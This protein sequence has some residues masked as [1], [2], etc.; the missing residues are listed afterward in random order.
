MKKLFSIFAAILFAASISGRTTFNYS[1]KV[2]NQK[3]GGIT[4]KLST[5]ESLTQE[6]D[7]CT[8]KDEPAKT[9]ITKTMKYADWTDYTA[10][11]EAYVLLCL[12]DAENADLDKETVWA[13]LGFRTTA[14]DTK[15]GVPAGTYSI[16]NTELANTFMA[17]PGSTDTDDNPSLLYFRANY[18][19]EYYEPFYL[20]SGTVS[21]APV[22]NGV[23]IEVNATSYNGSS[24]KLSY[25]GPIKEYKEYT[26]SVKSADLTMGT[27]LGEGVYEQNSNI[28]IAATANPGY[29]FVQWSD[30]NTD[31]PREIKI[32]Q[33]TTF[34]AEFAVTTSGYCGSN[35]YWNFNALTSTLTISGSGDMYTYAAF[36]DVPWYLLTAQI[37]KVIIPEGLTSIDVTAFSG[38]T[39]LKV[40]VWNAISYTA[41]ASETV[42]PFYSIRTRI[43]D[44]EFGEKVKK[45]PAYLCYEM[46]A[47]TEIVLGSSVTNIGKH[48]FDGCEDLAAITSEATTPPNCGTDAFAGVSIFIPVYVPISSIEKYAKAPIWKDFDAFSSIQAETKTVEVV[49]ATP[50]ENSVVMKWPAADE[51][52]VYTLVIKRDGVTFCTLSFNAQGQL[53][54]IQFVPG[55]NGVHNATYATQTAT[56]WQFTITSLDSGT[57]Y[58]YTVTAK[59]SDDTPVYTQSGSF[60]TTGTTTPIDQIKNAGDSS[61]QK[62]LHNGVLYILRDGKVYSV[63]GQ[64]V[65]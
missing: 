43:A 55:R 62:I 63:H 12:S 17:S 47:L 50:S 24:I 65:K 36:A 41:P 14:P 6:D 57:T 51:A 37:N 10:A 35:L 16:N 48:A 3:K 39:A 45:I 23:K 28:S 4:V 20:V 26:L 34:I 2:E 1:N 58:D 21:I 18:N 38:C 22:S 54:G 30:G 25:E 46:T 31:N 11:K 59:K 15:L 52:D 49:S 56:G 44:I 8:Y 53:L 61:V 42:A 19:I 13:M 33:D 29:H 60:T 27:V 40:I 64:E 32:T 5:G 7:S 9:S